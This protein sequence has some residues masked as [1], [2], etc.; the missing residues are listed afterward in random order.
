MTM[1]LRAVIDI[2]SNAIRF[3]VY[4]GAE[5]APTPI[6][7]E[8]A[9]ISLGKA[10]GEHGLIPHDLV[11]EAMRAL[12]RFAKLCDA[13]GVEQRMTIATAAVRDATNGPDFLS[14]ARQIIPEIQL[15]TGDEEA[16]AG[17]HG[18][19]AE[20]PEAN[21]VAADLGGGSLELIR[22]T[23]GILGDRISVPMGTMKLKAMP[24]ISE[25]LAKLTKDV[26]Q[27]LRD[28]AETIFL[29]GGAWRAM[30]KF[31]HILS[32]HPLPLI[33]NH[34]V[35]RDRLPELRTSAL[36][37]ELLKSTRG[38][39][40]ARLSTL[41]DA[42]TLAHAIANRFQTDHLLVTTSGIR[43]G[44]LFGQLDDAT[45]RLN[46]AIE[47]IRHETQSHWRFQG[48]G[49]ALFHW[50]RPLGLTNSTRSETLLHAT[51]CF[52]DTAWAIQPDFRPIHAARL[53]LDGM[54]HGLLPEERI[55]IAFA[56][57]IACGGKAGW[58]DAL[59]AY[60]SEDALKVA[61]LWGLA[62]RLAKRL[63]AGVP[64]MLTK[65]SIGQIERNV[66]LAYTDDQSSLHTASVER[67][68]KALA[69][70]LDLDISVDD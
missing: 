40:Q 39:P 46:P 60:V 61:R 44:V 53:A 18:I 7:N 10:V 69:Q 21:G 20:F 55:Q 28:P 57:F 4:D 67:R 52:A 26:P 34:R 12:T 2:G 66:K 64:E 1:N 13:M 65:A 29:I 30:A 62:I 9:S 5:R 68:L 59:D 35:K 37:D 54:W 15:L 19:L 33:A 48:F 22:L 23:N 31:D 45:K 42:I 41:A 11:A 8:K 63:S 6:Y 49:D 56:T 14:E 27:T 50:I 51:C 38:I 70:A 25:S 16:V 47:S 24:S 17:G 3:V 58:P 32:D 36:N 43:E